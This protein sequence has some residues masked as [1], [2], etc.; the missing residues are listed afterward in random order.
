MNVPNILT[1]SRI[2]LAVVLVVLLEQNTATGYLLAAIV[3]AFASLTDFYDGYLA[4][5]AGLISDFGKIM[6]PIA[7]KVLILSAFGVLAHIGM[8]PWWM[9]IVIAIRE[10]GV[11]AS[12][13][14]AMRHGRVLA[15][16]RAGKVKTVVQI[17]AISSILLYLVAQQSENCSF[18]FY[19]AQ[20]AWLNINDVLMI[21]AVIMTVYSG[22]D[23]FRQKA[24]I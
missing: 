17:I 7:D 11:T 2:I 5:K 6:D 9:F 10:I 8:V 22:I 23:Y 16:E 3:F 18:W 1:I 13:L 12:R 14:L 15:A 21:W 24:K 20:R 19:H 4:K